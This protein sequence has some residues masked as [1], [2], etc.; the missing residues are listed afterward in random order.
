MSLAGNAIGKMW[1]GVSGTCLCL[2]YSVLGQWGLKIWNVLSGM[3][4]SDNFFQQWRFKQFEFINVNN[5]MDTELRRKV[6]SVC[7]GANCFQNSAWSIMQRVQ[8]VIVIS[9]EALFI[10]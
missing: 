6:Q 9:L 5:I 4:D 7:I 8:I 3:I 10:Q 2:Q 1:L